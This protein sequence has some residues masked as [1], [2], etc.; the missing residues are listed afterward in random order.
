M[1]RENLRILH[2]LAHEPKTYAQIGG[3]VYKVAKRIKHLS[4]YIE[5]V[6][7]T[8]AKHPSHRQKLWALTPEGRRYVVANPLPVNAEGVRR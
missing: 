7:L 8:E 5:C 1:R 2:N 6:G 3:V 4:A